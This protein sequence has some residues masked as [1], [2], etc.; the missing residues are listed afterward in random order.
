MSFPNTT[1]YHKPVAI[2]LTFY[3]LGQSNLESI[4]KPTDPFFNYNNANP[5]KANDILNRNFFSINTKEYQNKTQ[6]QIKPISSLKQANIN[7]NNYVNPIY[8][9]LPNSYSESNIKSNK[10]EMYNLL[11]SKKFVKESFNTNAKIAKG[12]EIS[13]ETFTQLKRSSSAINIYNGNNGK[14]LHHNFLYFKPDKENIK[15]NINQIHNEQYGVSTNSK[16]VPHWMNI[17]SINKTRDKN[18]QIFN[19]ENAGKTVSVFSKFKSWITVDGKSPS[20]KKYLESERNNSEKLKMI[21]PM[22]M[23][24]TYWNKNYKD[25]NTRRNEDIFKATAYKIPKQKNAKVMCLIE[26]ENLKKNSNK[27]IFSYGD[28]RHNVMYDSDVKKYCEGIK[29]KVKSFLI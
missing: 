29:K 11:K 20:R 5:D 26:K 27:A 17:S 18:K 8:N 21:K 15:Q 19:E 13:K 25:K 10:G 7:S 23:T 16:G 28:Y 2:P 4:Y 3:A 12:Q 14:K 1:Y 22:W 6:T 24:T 9:Y